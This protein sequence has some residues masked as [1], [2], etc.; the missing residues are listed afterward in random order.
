MPDLRIAKSAPREDRTPGAG[1][2]RVRTWVARG[3]TRVEDVV[4][5]GLGVLLA[6]TALVLLGTGVLEFARAL[7]GGV[8]PGHVVELLD[9]ILLILMIVEFLYT[10]QVSLRDHALVPEPFLI[11]GLI[12]VTRRLLVLTAEF[13]R[14]VQSGD[15]SLRTAMLELGLLSLMMLIL[16]VSLVLL[17]RVGDRTAVEKA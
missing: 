13:G 9:R 14:L 15:V 5:V 2:G 6:G 7:V 17:R 4:Y 16:V 12:A 8:L 11:I 3:F 1:E 10:V